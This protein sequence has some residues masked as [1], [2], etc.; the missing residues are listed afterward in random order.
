MAKLCIRILPNP[1]TTDPTLDVLRTQEGDVVWVAEDDH[2]F[3]LGEL[4]C[5]Q[6]RFI[7]VPGIQADLIYL[8]EPVVDADEQMI[9]RR[10]L[11]L[12]SSALKTAFWSEK[13]TATKNELD[14]ITLTKTA[15]L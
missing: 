13:T 1:N 15:K 5:G 4:N 6:Y 9:A 11:T 7:D 3:S 14:S 10:K 12:D 2:V 8:M